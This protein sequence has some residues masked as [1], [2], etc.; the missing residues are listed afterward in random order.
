MFRME[1]LGWEKSAREYNTTF[2]RE[3]DSEY[4]TNV[5]T[6][7]RFPVVTELYSGRAAL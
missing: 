3:T 5:N 7:I 6:V 2:S 4:N 1:S